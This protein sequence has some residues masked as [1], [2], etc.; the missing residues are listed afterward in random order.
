MHDPCDRASLEYWQNSRPDRGA[1]LWRTRRERHASRP[2]RPWRLVRSVRRFGCTAGGGGMTALL[3]LLSFLVPSGG[4]VMLAAA[5]G[6][7][8]VVTSNGLLPV[9]A[10]LVSASALPPPV[11]ECAG[12][13][14]L[15]RV[16]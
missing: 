16:C 4:R 6:F 5:L 14:D 9:A 12:A 15:F 8:A 3:R 13:L 1:S 7:A 10:C 2:R 11:G